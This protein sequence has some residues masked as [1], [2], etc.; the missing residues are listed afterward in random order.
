MKK[1]EVGD[2]VFLW[3]LLSK[4]ITEELIGRI[5]IIDGEPRYWL[6]D[7]FGYFSNLYLFH[8]RELALAKLNHYEKE[9]KH[10]W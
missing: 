10:V 3:D 6:K 2:K 7:H 4:K 8:T 9:S 5:D 1:F